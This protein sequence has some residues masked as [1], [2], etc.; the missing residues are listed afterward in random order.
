MLIPAKPKY[1]LAI[2]RQVR[3]RLKMRVPGRW[4]CRTWKCNKTWNCKI[5]NYKSWKC[6]DPIYMHTDQ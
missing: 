6:K 4:K 3:G 5:W 2:T 1:L